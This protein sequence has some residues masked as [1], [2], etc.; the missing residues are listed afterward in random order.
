MN[1]IVLIDYA[2]HPFSLD[3]ANSLA[4]KKIN[5]T[6]FF[7]KNIN[8]TGSYYKNFKSKYINFRPIK[9]KSFN[10][11]NFLSRRSS[12]IEFATQI[13]SFLKKNNYKKIILANIPIDS[14]YRIICFCNSNQIETYFWIQDIYYLAIKNFFKKNILLYIFF[15]F[16]ISKFYEYLEKYCFKNS[17]QNIIIDDNFKKFFPKLDRKIYTIHNWVPLNKKEKNISKSII[18]NKLKIKKKFTFIYTGTLSYKHHF[19]NIIKL[20]LANQDSQILIFSNNRFIK[21]IKKIINDKLIK[22]IKIFKPVPYNK[23]HNYLNIANVGLVNL[24]NDSNNVCVPSKVLTYYSNS[25]P[26]L[27]SMPLSNLASKNIKKYKTGLVC[28]PKSIKLYLK[29]AHIL[30]NNKHL[31]NKLSLNCKNYALKKF[32]TIRIC[33]IF[34]NILNI[35]TKY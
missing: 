18:L 33:E 30:K 19:N 4:N 26:V 31:R 7:S 8:L 34:L 20:A 23:L 27:G 10:K 32:D 24:N 16:F 17:T 11:Y 9:T 2:C 5:I 21:M 13:I 15:G 35:E 22:N 28:D 1:K 25:L 14:L 12:E 29:N 3:L 6:Y